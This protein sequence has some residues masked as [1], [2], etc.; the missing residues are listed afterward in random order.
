L[1]PFAGTGDTLVKIRL[2]PIGLIK[3]FAE[4]GDMDLPEGLTPRTLVALL[5]IPQEL[6]MMAFVNGKRRDLDDALEDG[7][8]VRLVT[9]VTGG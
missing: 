4:E 8:E 9:I 6:K 2:K 1:A 5:Q 3:R 7:D